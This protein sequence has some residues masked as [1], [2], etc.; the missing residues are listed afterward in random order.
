MD[1]RGLTKVRGPHIDPKVGCS[2][3]QAGAE[4]GLCPGS[5]YAAAKRGDIPTVRFGRRIIVPRAAW[6]RKKA[7]IEPFDP[8]GAAAERVTRL[9]GQSDADIRDHS[10]KM[11]RELNRRREGGD[12]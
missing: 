6:E 8:I 12:R 9:I 11:H 4:I 3:P 1:S 10:I 5:S 2:V 7:G